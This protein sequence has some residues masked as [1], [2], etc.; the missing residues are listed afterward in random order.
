MGRKKDGRL[1]VLARGISSAGV[2]TVDARSG[3]ADE[4]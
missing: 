1:P 3:W 2:R 4:A